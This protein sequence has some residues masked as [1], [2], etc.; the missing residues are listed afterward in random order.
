MPTRLTLPRSLH[1]S[2]GDV[3]GILLPNCEKHI[4]TLLG[5]WKAGKT[6]VLLNHRLTWE[7]LSYLI[8][9]SRPSTL[10]AAQSNSPLILTYR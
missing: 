5:I 3:V 10:I 1:D 8:E 7:E 4:A 2:K 6:A 9:D